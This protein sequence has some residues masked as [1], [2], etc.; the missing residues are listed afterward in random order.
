LN[1]SVTTGFFERVERVK[2]ETKSAAAGVITILTSAPALTNS[3][4]RRIDLYAAIL[5]EMAIRIFLPCSIVIKL[6]F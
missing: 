4:V 2:G 6:G 3:L 5:P 1:R